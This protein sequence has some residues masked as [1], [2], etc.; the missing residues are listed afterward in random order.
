MEIKSIE[1]CTKQHFKNVLKICR[2]I[3]K[4]RLIAINNPS[5]HTVI[6]Y[7]VR[8][9][10]SGFRRVISAGCIKRLYSFFLH[11]FQVEAFVSAKTSDSLLQQCLFQHL[12][13]L[14]E[15]SMVRESLR[16]YYGHFSGKAVWVVIM[17][18]SITH[19]RQFRVAVIRVLFHN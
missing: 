14:D 3:N 9:P 16:R 15:E 1:K 10:E 13:H 17:F 5:H 18:T 2:Q 12:I 11:R 19:S 6:W 7:L 4:S 8:Q